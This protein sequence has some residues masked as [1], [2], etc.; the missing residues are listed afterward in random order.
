MLEA[1][2]VI[3]L[4]GETRSIFGIETIFTTKL[5]AERNSAP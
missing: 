4:M 1:Y 2:D 3:D 5:R